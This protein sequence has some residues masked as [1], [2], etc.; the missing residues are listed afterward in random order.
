MLLPKYH[1]LFTDDERA[2]ARRRLN[3]TYVASCGH[4]GSHRE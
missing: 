2:E 3:H 4:C 1:D